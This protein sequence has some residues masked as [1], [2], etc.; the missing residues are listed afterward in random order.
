MIHIIPSCKINV[1]IN[2]PSLVPSVSCL[3]SSSD[4]SDDVRA[5]GNISH[6]EIWQ[7][8]S[9]QCF[10]HLYNFRDG[11]QVTQVI[12]YCGVRQGEPVLN[13]SFILVL[14]FDFE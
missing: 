1:A 10:S 14:E 7:S 8:N 5:A 13:E 3:T 11:I 6:T 4:L 12:S 9:C 2:N